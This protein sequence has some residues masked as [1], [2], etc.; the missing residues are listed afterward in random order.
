[1]TDPDIE[2]VG[3]GGAPLVFLSLA[4]LAFL[5]STILFNMDIKWNG[6]LFFYLIKHSV[7]G[8]AWPCVQTGSYYSY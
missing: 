6:T 3:G 7:N 1:M 4:P 5:P 2:R 8:A